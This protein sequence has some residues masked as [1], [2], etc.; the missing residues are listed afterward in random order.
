MKKPPA[1]KQYKP[2]EPE[3]V[4]VTIAQSQ[5]WSGP[6]PSPQD[7]EAFNGVVKDGA[8][9]IVSAW[10]KE[11]SHRHEM[12][13]QEVEILSTDLKMGKIFALLFV[14]AALG[15]SGYCAYIGAEWMGI[16]LGGGT[17]SAV[18][19]AFTSTKPKG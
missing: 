15:L 16:I 10:E 17:I 19:Y 8:E 3:T 5:S 13:K 14:L 4:E 7:L 12:E 6:L 1:K 18:V 9:R 2:A 11:T